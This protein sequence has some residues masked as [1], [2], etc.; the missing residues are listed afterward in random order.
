MVKHQQAASDQKKVAV[1]NEYKER[2][3]VE[4]ERRA[5]ISS[6]GRAQYCCGQEILPEQ[7]RTP[8]STTHQQNHQE[9][10]IRSRG[11]NKER[12]CTYEEDKWELR[13]GAGGL[14]GPSDG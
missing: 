1:E 4:K 5:Q 12:K 13:V 7:E 9:N 8:N 10:V 14:E 11:E 2:P 6:I 3:H